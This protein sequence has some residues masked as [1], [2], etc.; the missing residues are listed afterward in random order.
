M[1]PSIAAIVAATASMSIASTAAIAQEAPA[2]A[3]AAEATPAAPAATRVSLDSPIEAIAAD[4]GGKAVL[5]AAVPGITSH[6]AY[7]QFKSM[8]LKQL[9]PYSQGQITDDVL[10][11]VR[12]GLADLK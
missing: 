12:S 8:S 5:D 1:K 11:K 10:T 2:P 4:P 3:T 9:Q 7:A 6:P